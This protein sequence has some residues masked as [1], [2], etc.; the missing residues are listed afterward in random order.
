MSRQS[1]EG[2]GS[3]LA[4]NRVRGELRDSCARFRSRFRGLERAKTRGVRLEWRQALKVVKRRAVAQ[5][6]LAR[7]RAQSLPNAPAEPDAAP[8]DLQRIATGSTT[9]G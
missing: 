9:I 7:Q 5:L 4:D 3:S 8:R 6:A 2:V 1:D